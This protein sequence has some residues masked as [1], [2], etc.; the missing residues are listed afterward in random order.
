MARTVVGY[1]RQFLNNSASASPTGSVEALTGL[2]IATG[3]EVGQFQEFSDALASQYASKV[4]VGVQILTAGSGQTNGTYTATAS[5]GGATI[6]YVIAGNALTSVTITGGGVY[7]TDTA[8][9][10][11]IAAA[12]TPGT[13]SVTLGFLYAGVYG[14]VQL[15]PA[16]TG[17]V[18]V[19]AALYWLQTSGSTWQVTTVNSGNN[20]D[21]A[22]WSIDPGFGAALP[23][24]YIQ[25]NGKVKALF[26]ASNATAFGD[27]VSLTSTSAGTVTRTGAATAAATGLTVGIALAIGTTLS[28]SLIRTTRGLGRV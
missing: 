10:F 9:T 7:A 26:D 23:Y 17:T 2:P 18:A 21:I 5:T 24:A 19:G 1:I 20:P 11:T 28:P 12:G 14:W 27:V 25:L 6:S 13:V 16:V 15:D 8:P 22:G 4:V 3:L